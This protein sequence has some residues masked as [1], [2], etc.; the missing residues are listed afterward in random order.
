MGH[1]FQG[2]IRALF[3]S[4]TAI[5]TL[6]APMLSA[7]QEGLELFLLDVHADGYLLA[8]SVPAYRSGETFLIDFELFLDAVEFP[9]A[10]KD[11]SWTGWF[12]SEDRRFSWHVGDGR[13]H[14]TGRDSKGVDYRQWMDAD[15]GTF[16]TIEALEA[17]FDLEL[18]V[19][20]RLQTISVS[21]S[22]ALPFQRWQMRALARYRYRPAQRLEPD[23]T[24]PDQYHWATTPLFNLTTQFLTQEQNGTHSNSQTGSIV[25]GMDLLKH[26]VTYAGGI[27][28]STNSSTDYTNRLTIEKNSATQ[29]GTLFWGVNR[30]TVGDIFVPNPNLIVTANTGRGFSIE[31]YPSRGAGTLGRVNITGDAPPGWEVE[32]YRNGTLVEFGSVNADGRYIFS[33]Q[34]VNFGENIFVTRLFGPQ[35]QTREDR[36]TFWGGGTELD[37]GDYDFSI[38]HIDY[39]SRLLDSQPVDV[40]SLAAN[41]ATDLHYSYALTGDLQL[42]TG[43]T[44]AGLGTRNRDGTFSDNHYLTLTGRM[45]LGRGILIAE[46]AD[47]LEHGH[48]LSLEYLTVRN[49]HNISFAHLG[50]RNF[51]SPTTIHNQKLHALNQISVSGRFG[52]NILNGYTL[53]LRH[54][55]KADGTSDFRVFNRLGMNLGLLSLSN[56]LEYLRATQKNMVL[57]QVK[58]AG[59]LGRINL[60]GQLNYNPTESQML[61]QISTTMT[62]DIN[63]RLFNNLVVS[64]NLAGDEHLN[65]NNRLSVRIRDFDLT[66][67]V[68]TN[69]DDV[70]SLGAGFNLRF[71]YDRSQGFITDRRSLANTGRATMN[72][73][74]DDNNNGIRDSGELPVPWTRYKDEEIMTTSPGTVSLNALPRYRPVQIETRNFEFDDPFL[75]PRSQVYELYTHVGSDI[76]VDV[77]VVLT[78]DVEG[79]VLAGSGDDAA[80]VKGVTVVLYSS[81]G[82][83]IAITRSEFDGFYSFTTIPAGDYEIRVA[84]PAGRSEFVQQFSLD[85]QEGYVV[86][87]GIYLYE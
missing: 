29:D 78:G 15:D 24:V 73:F 35:G 52:G 2:R 60:R 17:W 68:N 57:G 77:A 85:P 25:M 43:F 22:E 53:R 32:L 42:G 28:R 87:D 39:E 9:I 48:A 41:Y 10:R 46:A 62:W 69:L 37:K 33:N 6:L 19:N 75:V 72:L 23:V 3:S 27:T 8:E 45:K 63:E 21:S 20:P 4:I 31:R 56:D 5:C 12:H 44:Q 67:S 70:W 16:V 47:Q 18:T 64:K 59:R 7:A 82:Q 13:V 40:H 83:E 38:S 86:L 65:L 1:R 81:D 55:D 51:E 34:E 76:S 11:Q 71:G 50:F 54:R 84:G 26:S 80:S 61:R 49:G 74:I 14:V 58:V 79:H 30:Y 36:Q 66:L